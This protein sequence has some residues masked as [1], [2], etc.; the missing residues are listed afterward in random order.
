MTGL[1]EWKA[2]VFYCRKLASVFIHKKTESRH[3]KHYRSVGRELG[4]VSVP[5]VLVF[6]M[7]R[8]D[9][10]KLI[11]AIN[12][13]RHDKTLKGQDLYSHRTTLIIQTLVMSRRL[14]KCMFIYKETESRHLKHYRSVGRKLS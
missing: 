10:T 1:N 12:Q 6:E 5:D 8:S 7:S 13:A 3:L 4:L 2:G 14:I 9:S 11:V